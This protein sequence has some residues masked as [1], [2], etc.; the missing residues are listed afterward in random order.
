MGMPRRPG[1]F[2]GRHTH[3]FQLPRTTQVRAALK[4]AFLSSTVITSLKAGGVS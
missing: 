2:T 3:I 1:E 4:K